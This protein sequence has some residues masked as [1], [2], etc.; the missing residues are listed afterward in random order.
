MSPRGSGV[1]NGTSNKQQKSN[2]HNK[3]AADLQGI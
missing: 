3:N 2:N 1:S